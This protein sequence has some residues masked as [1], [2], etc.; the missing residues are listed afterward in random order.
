MASLAQLLTR[1]LEFHQ[2]GNLDEAERLYREV[3]TTDPKQAD[4]LHLLGMAAHQRGRHE[5][6]CEFVSRA[7]ALRPDEAM[8]HNNLGSMQQALGRADLAEASYR[9]ALQLNARHAAALNNLGNISR[10]A[11]RLDEAG[12]YYRRAL[13]IQPNFAEAAN[14]LG[15]VFADLRRYDEALACYRKALECQPSYAE[16]YKNLGII[17]QEDGL[18]Q[19]ATTSF[20]R[21]LELSPNDAGLKL[22][23]AFA[24]PVIPGS[25]EEIDERRAK[26]GNEIDR[27]MSESLTISDPVRETS[28]PVFHLAYHGRDARNLQER[29]ARLYLQ[30]APSLHEVAPHC[31]PGAGAASR[32]VDDL[33]RVGIVSRFLHNH[34]IGDHYAG[35][36]RAFPARNVRYTVFRF[37]GPSD[38]VTESI[39][40]AVSECVTLPTRL[41]EART[42]IARRQLDVL[43]YTDIG[44][45][46]WTYFLGFARLAPVQCVTLGQP[47]TTGIPNIDYFLSYENIETVDAQAHYSETLVRLKHMPHYFARPVRMGVTKA[48][49]DFELPEGV[50]LYICPQ[51]LFKLHPEFDELLAKILRA[52]VCGQVVLF[53]AGRPSWTNLLARRMQRVMGETF[54]RVQ[55]LP[56][57]SFD[58]FL[59]I[60]ELADV[61]LDTI[62]FCGGTTSLQAVAVGAPLVTLPGEFARGRGTLAHFKTMGVLDT[63]AKDEADYVRLAV[64]IANNPDLRARLRAK[65]I[66]AGTVLFDNTAAA[67]ELEAFFIEAAANR[68]RQPLRGPHVPM[69]EAGICRV[70]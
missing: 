16:A 29:I 32:S 61:L 70:T 4:A 37:S 17:L 9:R 64:E 60:L 28:G 27:L 39:E 48:R 11:W 53:E 36:I 24:L 68:R 69:V 55:F 65:I 5:R 15:S 18:I 38:A 25:V 12:D 26:L 44:M 14:N 46:P 47:V 1:A 20:R 59:R 67:K 19:E 13:E 45:D 40:N 8:F 66:A 6:G 42:E 50:P 35:L 22:R 30:A 56:R 63:V 7:I 33:V 21:A 54:D 2:K 43:L 52:D 62:H 34:S 41:D 3:L 10:D 51:T 57:Q 23:S 49:R 31:L 58:D